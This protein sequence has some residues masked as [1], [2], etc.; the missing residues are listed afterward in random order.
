MELAGDNNGVN[1]NIPEINFD[2]G[3]DGYFPITGP[4]TVPLT[5][6]QSQVLFGG[7][8]VGDCVSP[9]RLIVFINDMPFEVTAGLFN[10]KESFGNNAILINSFGQPILTDEFGVTLQPLQNG[11]VYYLVSILR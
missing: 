3:E 4:V 8:D 6:N 5:I 10:V 11:A 9:V 7:G 2:G 1:M